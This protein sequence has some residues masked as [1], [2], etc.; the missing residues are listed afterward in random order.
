MGF[1]IRLPFFNLK[2]TKQNWIT[3]VWKEPRKITDLKNI[4]EESIFEFWRNSIKKG[5]LRLMA[6]FSTSFNWAILVLTAAVSEHSEGNSQ[7]IKKIDKTYINFAFS[8]CN[9]GS[10]CWS[11]E[12]KVWED[13]KQ[14]LCEKM[15]LSFVF[16]IW[17]KIAQFRGSFG[18]VSMR[19]NEL[20]NVFDWAHKMIAQNQSSQLEL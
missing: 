17:I 14:I 19:L 8:S 3:F 11:V 4:C 20:E 7:T 18:S 16:D 9:K 1:G 13:F 2:I 12:K 10:K 15:I 6:H 5:A